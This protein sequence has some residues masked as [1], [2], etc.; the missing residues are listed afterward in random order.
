MEWKEAV[1][2]HWFRI[3]DSPSRNVGGLFRCFAACTSDDTFIYPSSECRVTLKTADWK[4]ECESKLCPVPE[5]NDS[6]KPKAL[7]STFQCPVKGPDQ[8]LAMQL[9]HFMV[10]APAWTDRVRRR[11]DGGHATTF[12]CKSQRDCQCGSSGQK[13]A[14]P[15]NSC[16][17]VLC[18]PA[19]G[20]LARLYSGLSHQ[21]H[22]LLAPWVPPCR[23]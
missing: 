1:K 6:T 13:T 17:A 8:I 11:R 19:E 5:S 9:A 21:S 15:S 12:P 14:L 4:S 22:S 2:T 23:S 10:A 16:G 20:L 3:N 18:V 7:K